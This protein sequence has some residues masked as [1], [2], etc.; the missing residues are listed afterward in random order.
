[1]GI[2]YSRE[3]NQAFAE[4]NKAYGQV[5]PLVAAAY[6]VL[7]T[8]KNISILLAAIQVLTV[9]LLAAILLTLVALLITLDPALESERQELVT[10]AL[11][12][13]AGWGKWGKA[14]WGWFSATA[15]LVM[16]GLMGWGIWIVHWEWIEVRSARR[17]EVDKATGRTKENKEGE[18]EGK[19]E[20]NENEDGEEEVKANEQQ[21]N[22][23]SG[24]KR[25][26]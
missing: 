4:L 3:I 6:E 23:K 11:K 14:G 19:E 20:G 17:A 26:K 9:I 21:T 12:Y 24:K 7:E 25:K 8:T 15:A 10:P 18:G 2:P 1:M 16:L 22:G 13:V 5:T